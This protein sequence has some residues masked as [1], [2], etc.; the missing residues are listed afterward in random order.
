[1]TITITITITMTRIN[2]K[3]CERLY[4]TMTH[5]FE[6]PLSGSD[7]ME[8]NGLSEIL[9]RGIL[10]AMIDDNVLNQRSNQIKRFRQ[11]RL[12]RK[13]ELRDV[14]AILADKQDAD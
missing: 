5:M 4:T 1:M 6:R 13:F 12:S 8:D 10:H 3:K 14:R 2:F 11:D 7:L 9:H